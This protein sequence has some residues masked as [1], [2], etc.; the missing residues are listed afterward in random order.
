VQHN[1]F[2]RKAQTAIATEEEKIRAA[3]EDQR[4]LRREDAGILAPGVQQGEVA[5]RQI[6]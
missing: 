3:K 6:V 5:A 1:P 2:V 4:C